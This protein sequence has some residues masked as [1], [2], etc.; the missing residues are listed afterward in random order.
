M[1]QQEQDM[2]EADLSARPGRVTRWLRPIA[3]CALALT[4][5][6][7]QAYADSATNAHEGGQGAD[8]SGGAFASAQAFAGDGNARASS[9]GSSDAFGA[10]ATD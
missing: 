2:A 4:L 10:A 3:A 6:I 9:A 8:K 1:G 7:G 5:G